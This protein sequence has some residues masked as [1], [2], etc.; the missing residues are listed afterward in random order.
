MLARYS[1]KS[2]KHA[3]NGTIIGQINASQI[4]QSR[5]EVRTKQL[6][7]PGNCKISGA[8]KSR[9]CWQLV[10]HTRYRREIGQFCME[11]NQ[12][13]IG[14]NTGTERGP[15]SSACSTG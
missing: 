14:G 13:H 11:L 1:H 10:V 9:S 2:V 7:P 4:A 6:P 8:R 15:Y 12:L 5:P 3:R